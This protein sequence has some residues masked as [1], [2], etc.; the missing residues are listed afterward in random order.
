M[1]LYNQLLEIDEYYV[2]AYG[3]RAIVLYN[4][5]KN[6]QSENLPVVYFTELLAQALGVSSGSDVGGSDGK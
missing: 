4:L 1:N 3:N 6:Q 5:N 2:E